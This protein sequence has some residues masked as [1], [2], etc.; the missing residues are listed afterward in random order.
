MGLWR[1]FLFN[2]QYLYQDFVF[3]AFII[4]ASAIPPLHQDWFILV[5]A[6]FFGKSWVLNEKSSIVE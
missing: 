4:F 2:T 5:F 1:S 3:I 6:I